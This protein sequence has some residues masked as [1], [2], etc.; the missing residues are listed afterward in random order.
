MAMTDV[1]L[2]VYPDDCDAFGHVNQAAFLRL[3]ER[4]RWEVLAPGPGM[5]LL[6]R[7]GAWPAVRKAVIDFHAP[8]FPG[9]ILRFHQARAHLGRTSFTLRQVARRQADETLIA[10]AEFVFVCI[11]RDGRPVPVPPEI[12]GAFAPSGG[13]DGVQR[14]TV[15]GVGLAV[16]SRG[17][18]PAV[19]FIHGYPLNRGIWHHQ[20]AQLRGVRRIAVDLRGMGGSDAPDLGYSMAT[21]AEDLAGLLDALGVDS[22]VLVGLSMGGYVALEFLRRWPS[23]VRG[24]VLMDTRAGADSAEGR[25]G[26][27][28]QLA[29]AR[30]EGTGAVAALMVPKLLAPGAPPALVAHLEQMITRTPL[31]GLAGALTAMRDRAD[32]TDLLAGLGERPVLVVSG[33]QDHLIPP[34]V[35]RE[36]AA[37]IPGARFE[38]VPG[39]GHLPPLEQ[40]EATTRI[41]QEFLAG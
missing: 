3:F 34:A 9:D 20:V 35:A 1:D 12:A 7:G 31:A 40:P 38:L 14:V 23:R 10:T 13:D 37:A 25:K 30:E 15:R 33:E 8:A 17:Q 26:R 29:L 28:A 32:S 22:A 36:L 2:T 27:D 21:Y 24:L 16:E 4:A 11:N 19:L 41:L 5:D 39:A 6:G 18:G